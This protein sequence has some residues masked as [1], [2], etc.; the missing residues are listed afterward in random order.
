MQQLKN[1]TQCMQC[2]AFSK[3]L[4]YMLYGTAH[5]VYAP[6]LQKTLPFQA[7]P[8]SGT[9]AHCMKRQCMPFQAVP[10]SGTRHRGCCN[11]HIAERS[12]R[13]P[14]EPRE[15]RAIARARAGVRA[16]RATRAGQNDPRETLQDYLGDSTPKIIYRLP[17]LP[18]TSKT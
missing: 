13:E 7:V 10:H 1:L 17:P 15:T 18:P 6:G 16:T 9:R 3:A 2:F 11:V 12:S 14:R 5:L 8:R 4:P